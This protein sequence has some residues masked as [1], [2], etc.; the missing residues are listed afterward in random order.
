MRSIG[1]QSAQLK[2]NRQ[3]NTPAAAALH[4]P[5]LENDISEEDETIEF[6]VQAKFSRNARDSTGKVT[7]C[8][9]TVDDLL[10]GDADP[11]QVEAA[12]TAYGKRVATVVKVGVAQCRAS[13]P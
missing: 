6:M 12:L 7:G 2:R 13:P 9:M 10:E 8:Y 5:S 1:V 11:K 3:A 4:P